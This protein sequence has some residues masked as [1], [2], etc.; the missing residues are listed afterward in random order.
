[1]NTNFKVYDRKI[2]VFRNSN[3]L[4][5]KNVLWVYVWSTNAY[6]TCKEAV[7]A[8]KILH[9]SCEFKASFAKEKTC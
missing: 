5:N 7:L 6:K 1:M 9:P 4:D 8:A 3:Q 2:H